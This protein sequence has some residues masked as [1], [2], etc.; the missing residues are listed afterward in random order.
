MW[1]RRKEQKRDCAAAQSRTQ[2]LLN[3]WGGTDA[4]ECL[5]TADGEL[6]VHLEACPDCR[7]GME[8]TLEARSVLRQGVAAAADPGA[9]FTRRIMLAVDAAA[10]KESAAVANTWMAVPALASRMA[11]VC[12]FALLLA[13]A[14]LHETRAYS[15]P[16][17]SAANGEMAL[18]SDSPAESE[19]VLVS[20]ARS[21]P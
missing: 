13:A 4:A 20:V 5:G 19:E 10:E 12:A 11:W 14:W 8:K 7:E 9:A 17:R 3:G 1:N 6:R 21:E 15:P 16:A 2:N 18:V